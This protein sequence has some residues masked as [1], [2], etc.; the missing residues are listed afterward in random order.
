MTTNDIYQQIKNAVIYYPVNEKK[1]LTPQTF[2]VLINE[3]NLTAPNLGATIL[4]KGGPLF[5]SRAWAANNYDKHNIVFDYPLVLVTPLSRTVVVNGKGPVKS[6]LRIQIGV[7]DKT[8]NGCDGCDPDSCGARSPEQV[9]QDTETMLIN[10]LSYLQAVCKY[11]T[12][13][14]N[15]YDVQGRIDELK[16]AS[17]LSRANLLKKS[18]IFG[19]A[20]VEFDIQPIE[21]L[22]EVV[23]SA[24]TFNVNL[25]ECATVDFDFSGAVV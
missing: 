10:I 23:G 5:L 4:D 25:S 1:C 6:R 9:R 17:L 3:A 21:P 12:D 24:A 20:Q 14:G 22:L 15:Q 11:D 18:V 19:E 16:R 13:F 2:R 8:T 7:L